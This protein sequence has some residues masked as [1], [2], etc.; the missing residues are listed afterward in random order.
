MVGFA[1]GFYLG[2]MSGRERYHQINRMIR[3]AK[4]S[5]AAR[6]ATAVMGGRVGKVV[7]AAT[8]RLGQGRDPA[9]MS[10]ARLAPA[11]PPI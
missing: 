2:T 4:R 10:G 7:D 9:D 5:G 6:R 11:V 3:R 1:T 8:E